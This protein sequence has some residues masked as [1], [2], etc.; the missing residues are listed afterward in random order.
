MAKKGKKKAKPGQPGIRVIATAFAIGAGIA[1]GLFAL[2]RRSR[3]RAGMGASSAA[4]LSLD[5]PHHGPGDR[6]DMDFR[7]DPTAP[8]PAD[9]RGAMAPAT[10]PNPMTVPPVV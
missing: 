1:A 3:G 4:D 9:R 7:P 5:Q 8:V 10:L 6:A 2:A